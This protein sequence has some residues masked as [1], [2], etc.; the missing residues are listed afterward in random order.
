MEEGQS[1]QQMVLEQL[2]IMQKKKKKKGIQK[3]TVDPSIIL[4]QNVLQ[5]NMKHK[6]KNL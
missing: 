1:F 6:R 3:Q 5:I 4:I 2:H